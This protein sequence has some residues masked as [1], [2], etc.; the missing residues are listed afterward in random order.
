[1]RAVSSYERTLRNRVVDFVVK[2]RGGPARNGGGPDNPN[3][4]A[5]LPMPCCFV[6]NLLMMC[7]Q[8][9]L[10]VNSRPNKRL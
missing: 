10:G 1:M 8:R 9:F 3:T 7:C 4:G 2:D 6:G 5:N